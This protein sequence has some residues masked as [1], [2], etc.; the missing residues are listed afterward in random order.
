M[1]KMAE[2]QEDLPTTLRTTF[3][4]AGELNWIPLELAK[5]LADAAG[6]RN[7]LVHGY[8]KLNLKIIYKSIKPALK[9]YTQFGESLLKII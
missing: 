2:E 4:R 3:L 1:H 7:L 5:N 6:M 9:D 8:E